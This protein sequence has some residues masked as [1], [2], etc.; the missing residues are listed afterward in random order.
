[1]FKRTI[2]AAIALIASAQAVCAETRVIVESAPSPAEFAHMLGIELETRPQ[3][4]TRGIKM[5]GE[6]AAPVHKAEAV[7][8]DTPRNVTV[9]APVNFHLDSVAI[10]SS[11]Q[12]HL[13]NLAVVLRAPGADSKVLFITGHTD[14]QGS[15]HYNLDLSSRRAVAVREYLA[16]RGVDP[17]KLIAIGKGEHEL[18]AGQE[19]N[20]SVNRRV[21]FRVAG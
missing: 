18:I 16:H 14:S 17:M 2:T 12:T 10:P 20:H 4:R 15:D 5:H 6:G 19:G 11:F 1:M 7:P 9:A 8:I 13:D 3:L 21:E